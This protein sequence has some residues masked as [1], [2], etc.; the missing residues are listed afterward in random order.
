MTEMAKDTDS[1]SENL[2]EFILEENGELFYLHGSP[3]NCS[4]AAKGKFL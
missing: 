2:V 1:N 4:R 3:A